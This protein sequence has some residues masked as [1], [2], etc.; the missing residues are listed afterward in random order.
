[1]VTTLL[2]CHDAVEFSRSFP[3]TLIAVEDHPMKALLSKE[4]ASCIENSAAFSFD[5]PQRRI[6]SL[7]LATG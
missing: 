1:V 6:S 5:E 2:L 7:A 3:G 4:R